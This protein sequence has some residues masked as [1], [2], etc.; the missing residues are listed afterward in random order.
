MQ[1]GN[2]HREASKD[3]WLDRR[4]DEQS[5]LVL[6]RVLEKEFASQLAFQFLIPN[7]GSS[8]RSLPK[9]RNDPRLSGGKAGWLSEE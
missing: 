3:G 6:E 7:S 2:L 5:V 1:Y 4:M 8:G 9:M